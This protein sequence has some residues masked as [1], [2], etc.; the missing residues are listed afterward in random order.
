MFFALLV[1]LPFRFLSVTQFD[2]M[3]W[4]FVAAG[5][6]QAALML[7]LAL[8]AYFKKN[9]Y[10]GNSYLLSLLL[11][12]VL[13]TFVFIYILSNSMIRVTY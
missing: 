8:A 10:L 3:F 2:K 6:L 12:I 5:I 1:L 7:T 11:L 9:R 4:W 13:G